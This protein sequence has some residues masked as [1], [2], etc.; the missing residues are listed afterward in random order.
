MCVKCG[1]GTVVMSGGHTVRVPGV[2]ARRRRPG[3]GQA[4]VEFALVAPL[5]FLL[6]FAFIEYA[7]IS[8]SIAAFNFAAKDGARIGSLLGRTDG[9]VDTQILTAVTQHV[10]G[11]VMAQ[12]ITLEIYRSDAAGDYVLPG[13]SAAVEDSY[14]FSSSSWT[15]QNWLP[16]LRDDTLINADYLGV[17]ITYQY[18]YLSAFVSGGNSA[19]QLTANAVERIEP[20]D[21]QSRRSPPSRPFVALTMPEG[22]PMLA[23]S[24]AAGLPGAVPLAQAVP[25]IWTRVWMDVWMCVPCAGGGV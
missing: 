2:R 6:L 1:V 5:F 20:Q 17:K 21:F 25:D 24:F 16:N 12:P 3:R 7:L 11:I 22:V 14:S 18:T 4:M 15:A 10:A 9:T 23:S 13:N 19:L 8:T